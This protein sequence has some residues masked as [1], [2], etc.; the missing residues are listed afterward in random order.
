VDEPSSGAGPWDDLE[1]W[2][3]DAFA[4]AREAT[5]RWTT[6]D[7]SSTDGVPLIGRLGGAPNVSVATG[8][9][10]WG[11]T[12]AGVA[13]ELIAGQIT[14]AEADWHALFDP[15][16]GMPKVDTRIISGHRTGLDTPPEQALAALAPGEARVL[17]LDGEEVAAYRDEAG[18]L[19][20]VSAA[21]THLGCIV[22]WD[23]GSTEWECPCHGSRFAPDGS[24]THGPASEPLPA[25]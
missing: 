9:G 2:G 5:W 21:C 25:R 11:L 18:E 17:D 10:G 24:V 20:R 15:A 23:S 4:G 7:Y 19:H 22:L 8:F 3:R 14:G 1:R 16:R 12:T 6:Q 13:G